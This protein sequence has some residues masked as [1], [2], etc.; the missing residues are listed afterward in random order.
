MAKLFIGSPKKAAQILG[1]VAFCLLVCGLAFF[2]RTLVIEPVTAFLQRNSSFEDMKS[3]LQH[4]YLS[5][6]F[7]GKF[8]LLTRNGGYARLQGRTQYN[9]TQRMTN[10]M[11]T[12]TIPVK[13][14]TQDFADSLGRFNR[15]LERN[16]IPFLFIM[17]PYKVPVEE[18]L[19]PAGV[20]DMTNA[21]ADQ[22]VAELA[23]QN[24]P[25]LD[26]RQ[27][28]SLTAAQVERYFYR[29][30]HHWNA[31]GSFFAFQKIMETIRT[32]FQDTSMNYADLMLWEKNVIPNWWLGTHGRRVGP[33]F[34]GVD[35]LDYYLPT[36]DTEMSRYSIGIW[37]YKG[38][39]RKVN[40]REWFIDHSDLFR[41]DNYQRYLGGGYA[42]T[43][44]RNQHAENRKKLLLIRDSFM[45]PVEC[46]LS[47]EFI[48]LDV[49]DPRE[50][51]NMNDVDYVK[52]NP[53]DMVIM[54]IYPGM[55]ANNY[56]RTFTNFG[57]EKD[58]KVTGEMF[59]SRTETPSR[60]EN[61]DYEVLPAHLESGKSYMLSLE[62]ILVR[63]GAPEGASIVL[64]D[65][66]SIVDQ[67]IFDIEYGNQFEFHWG[68]QIPE[69]PVNEGNYELRLY[70][71]ITGGT[72]N[73]AL[74]YQ[75]IRLQECLLTK[76]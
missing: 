62:K 65:G 19:L 35:D 15:Y 55:L 46:F 45:L 64:Y 12:N 40:I 32:V 74:T 2:N 4:N 33:L 72:E 30:D 27:E 10:G 71:G 60:A 69:S 70:A 21:L 73:V 24:V 75:G 58:L 76:Q 29:T 54:M 52:L 42:L 41:F 51:G 6:R 31:E 59:W 66:D 18:N 63:K 48:S 22:A 50:Y 13:T 56:Y 8:E 17:A 67:T 5:D 20:V 61:R 37:A 36:F 49:L 47:T 53:P 39:F 11:L 38:D 28:M 14:D 57:E 23:E 25:V 26:L 16:N 7:R 44:H 68:F 34:G 43:Y 1:C 3:T 9:G